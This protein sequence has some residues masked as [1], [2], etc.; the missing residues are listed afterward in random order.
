MKQAICFRCQHKYES[1]D[2]DDLAGDGKCKPC[3]ELSARI[4]TQ[5]DK[6]MAQKRM[7]DEAPVSRIR[8][9]FTEEEIRTGDMGKGGSRRINIKDLGI[10]PLD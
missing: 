7:Q 3:K 4:A 5:V 1:N 8:Q 2:P 10:T 9:L 6:Q